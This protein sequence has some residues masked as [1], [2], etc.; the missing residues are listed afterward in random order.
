MSSAGA[1][2][3][4]MWVVAPGEEGAWVFRIHHHPGI[5]K[6]PAHLLACHRHCVK[7]P[8]FLWALPVGQPHTACPCSSDT[9]LFFLPMAEMLMQLCQSQRDGTVCTGDHTPGSLKGNRRW[10]SPHGFK[11]SSPVPPVINRCY[12]FL[13]LEQVTD[14]FCS[15]TGMA[16][17]SAAGVAP[18]YF[19][20]VHSTNRSMEI[21][22]NQI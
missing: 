9:Q 17:A 12:I 13:S 16:A 10:Q 20:Y 18:R 4:G 2:L 8:V 1:D 14:F 7:R 3:R 22:N 11:F 19:S 21:Q 5:Q 15:V 6:L